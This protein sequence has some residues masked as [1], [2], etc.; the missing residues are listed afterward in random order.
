MTLLEFIVLR[1][2]RLPQLLEHLGEE[3]EE[4]LKISQLNRLD[5]LEDIINTGKR[6]K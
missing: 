5:L 3:R 2:P 6:I 4:L 1:D